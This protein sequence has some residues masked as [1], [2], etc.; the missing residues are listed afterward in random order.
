M[1][2]RFERSLELAR[3]SRSVV[4]AD[5]ELLLLLPVMPV[6]ALHSTM[7]GV[8]SAAPYRYAVDHGAPLPG[9][10]PQLLEG[11]FGTRR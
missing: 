3:A 10:G 8:Y 9:S 7:Q 11:A 2:G 6:V 4:R 1:P 5:K